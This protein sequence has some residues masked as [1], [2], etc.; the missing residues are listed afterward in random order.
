MSSSAEQFSITEEKTQNY[1]FFAIK[2]ALN[3]TNT[4]E[5]RRKLLDASN[6]AHVLLDLSGVD[7]IVSTGIGLLFEM[8]EQLS[9]A[10]KKLVLIAPSARVKQVIGM[11]GFTE[12][13]SYAPSRLE[14]EKMLN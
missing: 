5:I 8:S 14:A 13:F 2:G 4:H 1:T 12:M 3:S 7:M 6:R 10:N 11:T 9:R